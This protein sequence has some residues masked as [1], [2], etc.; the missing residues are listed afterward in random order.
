MAVEFRVKEDY[1]SDILRC[2]LSMLQFNPVVITFNLYGSHLRFEDAGHLSKMLQTNTTLVNLEIDGDIQND[3]MECLANGLRDNCTLK[4]LYLTA[5]EME[6]IGFGDI[7]LQHLSTALPFNTSI[8]LLDLSGNTFTAD[9]IR[10]LSTALHKHP[11]IQELYL[12][13]TQIGPDGLKHLATILAAEYSFEC[14]SNLRLL[15]IPR[16]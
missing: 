6:D 4:K 9:G 16:K 1:S 8:T 5:T 11:S 12:E 2:L 3:V 7:G 14:N 10:S 15:S 13:D